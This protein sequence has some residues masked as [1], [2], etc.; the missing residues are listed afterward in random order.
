MLPKVQKY[1]YNEVSLENWKE[2]AMVQ[3]RMTLNEQVFRVVDGIGNEK[4]LTLPPVDLW[5]I[6]FTEAP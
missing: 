6:S 2:R 4:Q 3:V 1:I 5:N